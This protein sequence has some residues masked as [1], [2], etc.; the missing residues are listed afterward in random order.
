VEFQSKAQE[1]SYRKVGEFLGQ[2]FG[3][4]GFAPHPEIPAYVGTQGSCMVQVTVYPWMNDAAVNVRSCLV[5]DIGDPPPELMRMLLDQSFSFAFGGF[6]L[7]P[8]GDVNFEE[9]LLGSKLDRE[10]LET[11]V[12]AVL[13]VSDEYDDRIV[14]DYGGVTGREKFLAMAKEAG[15]VK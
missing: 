8:N 9:T 10:E 14:R 1:E 4:T 7:D 11:A 6:T 3:T 2:S 15:F 13:S 5:M 12:Q